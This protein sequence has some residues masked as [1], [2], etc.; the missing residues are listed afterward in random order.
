[1]FST[2]ITPMSFLK[3]ICLRGSDSP[4]GLAPHR[5]LPGDYHCTSNICIY[6]TNSRFAYTLNQYIVYVVYPCTTCSLICAFSCNYQKSKQIVLK[7]CFW[8]C[9]HIYKLFRF[10][11]TLQILM[12]NTWKV[13]RFLCCRLPSWLSHIPTVMPV[14]YA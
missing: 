3:K 12:S 7:I 8:K 14:K 11:S 1:M 2:V 10:L 4:R 13:W 5:P 9:L 6:T